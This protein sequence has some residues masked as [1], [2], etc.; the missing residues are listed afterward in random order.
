MFQGSKDNPYKDTFHNYFC[1]TQR[2]TS[3][4]FSFAAIIYNTNINKI[5]EI[6]VPNII[7]KCQ[8]STMNA[9]NFIQIQQAIIIISI[10]TN[11][12]YI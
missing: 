6:E 11:L 9:I 2:Q 12:Y 10:K 4:D 3:S 7:S 1:Y 5:K 8:K